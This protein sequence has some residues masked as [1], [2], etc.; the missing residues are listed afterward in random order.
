M[1]ALFAA[2]WDYLME[3]NP[4]SASMLG[5]RRWNDRWPDVSLDAI[6]KRH[7]HTRAALARLQ[8]ID[9]NNLSLADQLNYDLFKR[10]YE[11]DVEEYKYRW[12]LVPLNQ[13]EGIQT[14]DELTDTLRFETVKD[15]EDWIARLRIFPTYINQT[16]QLMREGVRAVMVLPKIV[17]QRVPA[18]LDKQI[19]ER[20]ERSP[21]YKPFTR[22]PAEISST[23]QQRLAQS[24]R[25]AI[26]SK[27]IPA[28]KEF[29]QFFVSEYLPA[30][31]DQVGAW[32]M[33]QGQEMY[34]F[35]ARKYTTTKRTPQEIHET[36][37]AE[38]KRIRH[39]MQKVMDKVGFKGTLQDFFKHL[40]TDPRFYYKNGEELLAAYQAMSKRIDPQLVKVFKT[41]PRTPYGVVPIPEKIAPDTTTAYYNQPAADG[42]RAGLY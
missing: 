2:E 38:V 33:P 40:R 20:P 35:F 24:A 12:Y 37:L 6:G 23:E 26:A 30:S 15:Y 1:H 18:Q 34:A 9:R 19:V 16:T 25:E 36:G 28:F 22:F 7:E 11:T 13:R 10:E 27:V 8:T 21:Y 17:M 42:S 4:T 31:Y 5:D 32:Q 39:E 29:K 14:T 41:L 3:Q